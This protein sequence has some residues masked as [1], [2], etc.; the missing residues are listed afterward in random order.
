MPS[1]PAPL[2]RS[3]HALREVAEAICTALL[4]AI[5][6]GSGSTC[7]A[8]RGGAARRDGSARDVRAAASHGIHTRADRRRPD[9]ERG[10][11]HLRSAVRHLSLHAQA[12]LCGPFRRGHLHNRRLVHRFHLARQPRRDLRAHAHRQEHRQ[13]KLRLGPRQS[14]EYVHYVNFPAPTRVSPGVGRGEIQGVNL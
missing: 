11:G 7:G 2:Q 9:R 13:F 1:V 12:P 10:G 3:L 14:A 4:L 5:V 8:I 6:V